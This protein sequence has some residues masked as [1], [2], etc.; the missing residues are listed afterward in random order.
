MMG[1]VL[2]ALIVGF[3]FG[4]GVYHK[5]VVNRTKKGEYFSIDDSL[6]KMVKLKPEQEQP[7]HT[8]H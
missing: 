4:A 6:Y 2:F 5:S 8:V 3:L 7:K 1:W